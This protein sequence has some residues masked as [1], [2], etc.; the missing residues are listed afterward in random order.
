MKSSGPRA[1]RV[2]GACKR[3]GGYCLEQSVFYNFLEFRCHKPRAARPLPHQIRLTFCSSMHPAL[4]LVLHDCQSTPFTHNR[5]HWPAFVAN[6]VSDIQGGNDLAH[7]QQRLLHWRQTAH[8][9]MPASAGVQ[10]GC[11]RRVYT[12]CCI[13]A[14]VVYELQGEPFNAIGVLDHA[15]IIAGAAGNSRLDTIHDSIQALQAPLPRVSHKDSGV[16]NMEA[17]TACTV[18]HPLVS[19]ALAVPRISV[20]SFLQFQS[21][22]SKQPFIVPGYARDWPAL[23]EHPWRRA[24]Y[25]RS[26]SGP[27]RVVPVEIGGNYLLDDW[28][29]VLMSWDKFLSSL[30]FEDQAPP[31]KGKLYYLAQHNLFMQMPA[32][33][34]DFSVPDYAYASLVS[35]GRSHIPPSNENQLIV[36]SWLGPRGTVSPPHTVRRFFF[37]RRLY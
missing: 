28:K 8:A 17:S 16:C 36:N 37:M 30:H 34:D 33:Q 9:R 3:K 1:A 25:L 13:L 19:A 11:C 32:L 31:E 21:T 24:S 18:H 35:D 6:V 29:Q 12:D 5:Q 26:V 7:L 14:A 15:L 20:P 27:G 10:L 2:F 23:N 22:Q 4:A